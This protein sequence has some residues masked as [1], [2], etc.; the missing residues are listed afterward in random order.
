[1]TFRTVGWWWFT[2]SAA[3]A[4]S[5]SVGLAIAFPAV[6]AEE[7]TLQ[8]RANGEDF[9]RQGFVSKDGWQLDFEH[10]FVNFADIT[11]YQS[12]PPF[13]PDVGEE[14]QANIA[15]STEGVVTVDLAEGDQNADPV[16]LVELQVPPGRY[17]ALSWSM[18]QAASGAAAG[19]VM[20]LVG[21]A[22]KDGTTLPFV[23]EFDREY[24][25][26][27]GDFLGD[28]RKGIVTPGETADVEATL[29]FDHLFGDGTAEVN[30]PINTGAIGF[31]PLA[32]LARDNRVEVSLA[33]LES[34]LS[35]ENFLS[36][37]QALAGLGHVGENH[38]RQTLA[39]E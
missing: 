9:V 24:A 11:A 17:N 8:I 26:V 29:H 36:L 20:V 3:L 16:T 39:V 31:Q 37:T 27:C 19:Q 30:D 13:D 21:T 10:I 4:G 38:C 12:D 2:T 5:L 33:T 7:G 18:V 28:E 25:Y 1:M 34:E 6:S 14:P 32:D 35:Q 15:M 23:L 22:A